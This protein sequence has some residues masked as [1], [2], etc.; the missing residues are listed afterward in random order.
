MESMNVLVESYT[1]KEQKGDGVIIEGLAL[2]YGK[3][4]RNG[5]KYTEES[6]K[7]TYKTLE[8]KPV[9]YN[10]NPDRVIGHVEKVWLE[11]DGVHYRANID[12]AEAEIVR[13]LK[14]G[15]LKNVSIQVLVKNVNYKEDYAEIEIGEFLELSVVSIPGFADTSAQVLEKY[16]P[17]T[18]EDVDRRY[19]NP[20]G[21][22]KKMTCPDDPDGKPSKFCGCVRY[23]MA[24]K[25]LSLDSAKKLCAYIKR[26]KYGSA[27]DAEKDEVV[28]ELIEVF[29]MVDEIDAKTKEMEDKQEEVEAEVKEQEEPAPSD[30]EKPTDPMDEVMKRLAS[31]ED[32]LED[33]EARIAKLEGEQETEEQSNDEDEDE[34]KKEEP[35][36]EEEKVERMTA[37]ISPTKKEQV[38]YTSA[39]YELIARGE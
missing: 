25:G 15:D 38:I 33:L 16:K 2:P 23:F 20:D 7:A 22:F 36:E 17:K 34:D 4:S 21:T 5:N 14:R 11:A 18:K 12:P 13:K 1:V 26:K 6:I 3:V 32:K 27:L 37:P 28:K 30:D 24:K 39:L 31:I 9:L 10:H 29:R 19:Q 35:E 8:G